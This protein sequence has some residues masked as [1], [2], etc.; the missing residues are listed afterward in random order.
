MEQSQTKHLVEGLFALASV[1][2]AVPASADPV[3]VF[4]NTRWEMLQAFF[5]DAGY[6]GTVPWPFAQLAELW[7]G[8][9]F[10]ARTPGEF[11]RALTAAWQSER[12]SIVEVPEDAADHVIESLNG[13][14][15]RGRRVNARRDRQN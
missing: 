13:A 6:N 5:P 3:V 12:F 1:F 9:G 10:N 4:N 8:R 14:R 15:L 2:A 11:T 7:G